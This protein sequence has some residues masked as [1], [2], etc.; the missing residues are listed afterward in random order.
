MKRL[1]LL[2]IPTLAFASQFRY[3]RLGDFDG[4]VEVQLH[5][6]DPWQPALRNMPLPQSTWVRTGP[7]SHVEIELDEGSAIR[8][9]P[10]SLIEL[11]DYTR[12]STG[13]RITILSLDHGLAYFTGQAL[14]KD[15]LMVAVPGAQVSIHRGARVRLQAQDEWSQIGVIEGTVRFSS[16]GAELDLREGSMARVDPNNAARFFLYPELTPLD[17]DRWSEERDKALASASSTGHVGELRAGVADLDSAGTWIN[18]AN[19]GAVWKP[20]VADGWAPFKDGKWL[21][22][23]DLGYTWIASDAWGWLPYHHGRWMRDTETGWFWVPGKS[24]IFMPG[25]VYWLRGAK[26][27]AWGPLAYGENWNGSGQPLLFL[28][29]NTT[30]ATFTP[31]AREIDPTGFTTRPKEPLATASFV[32]A[33]PSP[34]F[35]AAR[36]QATR[37]PLRAGSTRIVPMISG[38]TYE[39]TTVAQSRAPAPPPPEHPAPPQPG[40]PDNAPPPM[41]VTVP[42]DQGPMEIFYPVPVYTG[43]VII[44]PPDHNR[45]YSRRRPQPPAAAPPAQAQEPPPSRTTTRPVPQP[46]APPPVPVSHTDPVHR[47]DRRPP[48]VVVQTPQPAPPIPRAEPVRPEHRNPNPPAAPAPAPTKSSDDKSGDKPAVQRSSEAAQP[49]RGARR[50]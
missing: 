30:W 3:A 23:D 31:D 35:I 4:K 16:P 37:P 47:D 14:P 6:A 20:K 18:T 21:W 32:L 46:T 49:E 34:A 11:S 29:A 33:L 27:A 2:L 8:L 13:Q 25:D 1:V 28:N 12:L 38:V 48:P 40:V 15:A 22:Y 41:V 17:T 50:Q 24:T 19:F 39:Q 26:V 43:V 42:Q 9:A 45:D 7:A 44:N 36:L 5:A 10:D